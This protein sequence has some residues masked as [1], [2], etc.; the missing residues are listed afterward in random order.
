MD[1]DYLQKTDQSKAKLMN[2]KDGNAKVE[3]LISLWKITEESQMV[4]DTELRFD[5]DSEY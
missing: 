5:Y 4:I 2:S 3:A 1:R